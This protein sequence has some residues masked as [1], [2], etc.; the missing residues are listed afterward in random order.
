MRTLWVWKVTE[1]K[2]QNRER[3]YTTW[4]NGGQL[5]SRKEESLQWFTMCTYGVITFKNI[6]HLHI[7]ANK[8]AKMAVSSTK[9]M[10]QTLFIYSIKDLQLSLLWT[11]WRKDNTTYMDSSKIFSHLMYISIPWGSNYIWL[12]LKETRKTLE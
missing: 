6:C 1:K 2:V 7:W 12:L 4:S 5:A 8:W 10:L 3:V 9:C 11:T